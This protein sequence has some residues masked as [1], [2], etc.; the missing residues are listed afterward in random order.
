MLMAMSAANVC[1]AP[2]KLVH[3]LGLAPAL[4]IMLSTLRW[5][6]RRLLLRS[7]ATED[8]Y[9]LTPMTIGPHAVKFKWTARSP[10]TTKAMPRRSCRNYLRDELRQRLAEGDILY[11]F[12]AQ[13]YIDPRKT[14]IDGSYAWKTEDTLFVKLA[15]LTIPAC[16]L[17]SVEARRTEV[18]LAGLSF[19][20]WHAIAEHR[21]IGNVQRGRRV[22]YEGSARLRGREPDH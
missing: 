9:G 2:F 22:I 16:D 3:D 17:D 5:L 4:R 15:E 18:R 10:V 8:F 13:F 20:P 12:L 6:P 11:D 21:P 7:I 19:N 14:P 1:T